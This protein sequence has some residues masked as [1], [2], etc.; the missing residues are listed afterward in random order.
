MKAVFCTAYGPP[1]VL[2]ITEVEKPAP[3]DNE[4]LVKIRATA[5]NSGDTR[6]RGFNVDGI[7]RIIMRFVLGFKKPRKPILGMVLSGKVEAVG[8]NVKTFKPGDEVFA[9]TGLKM[10]AYAQYTTIRGNGNIIH[11]PQN[12]SFE[13][14]TAILFGGTSAVY[15]LEKA[16]ITSRPNQKV[17]IYGAI[18]SVGAA[19]VQIAKHYRANVTSVCSEQ[20]VELANMIGSDAIV[21]YTQQDFT[22][23]DDKFDIV[24]DAVG[25]TKKKD[26]KELISE[27]GKY[28]TVGGMDIA[29]ETTEQMTFLKKLY[30]NEELNACIDR[31]YPMDE[32]VEAHRYVDTGR[33]KANV[34]V[35][36]K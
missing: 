35:K 9:C 2:K 29:K 6:I 10:G 13:E 1:E 23:L 14:A 3:K 27:G 18:G 5:V 28:I 12:A 31:T 32:I 24:F 20:G 19:A 30:E 26:C 22:K 33:K 17:L 8:K 11:K 15:F 36:V 25:K 21:L 7:F 16:G 4:V 34:V